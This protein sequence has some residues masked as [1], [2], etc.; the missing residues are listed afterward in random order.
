MPEV[1][2]IV[3]VYN[4][5]QF[6]SD[7]IKSILAQT[8]TDFEI[9][10]VDDGSKDSSYSICQE[11]AKHDNR[12]L[13]Y[14]KD[15]GGPGSARRYG[16][17]KAHGKY[18]NFVDA[19]D[20]IPETSI[21]D[22]Y[23]EMISHQLDIVQGNRRFIPI[24]DNKDIVSSFPVDGIFTGKDFVKFLFEAKC[25]AG[26]VGSLY[27]RVLFNTQTFNISDDVKTCEDLYMNICLGISAT[28]VG[29]FNNI[30]VY[31]YIENKD[32]LTHTYK[33]SSISPYMALLN[34]IEY[35]L[36]KNELLSEVENS[37]Y[38]YGVNLLA[39]KCYH[40]RSFLCSIE[41]RTFATRALPYMLTVKD[42]CICLT[43][44]YKIL[45]P[46]FVLANKIRRTIENNSY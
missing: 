36:S 4:S 32:S 27:N 23:S 12:V 41:V 43:L 39:S 24:N 5:E 8:F 26:P 42:K 15:N 22:L 34:S 30:I 9:I 10:L 46:I 6:L 18:I 28:K 17:S 38:S 37:F 13:A 1:S 44:K 3:P 33:L 21:K 29:L 11:W 20:I 31:N 7:C 14:T 2:I 35:I 25:N 45:F 16:V 40:N 19:D